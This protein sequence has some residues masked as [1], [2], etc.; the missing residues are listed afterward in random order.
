[1]GK[2][3]SPEEFL[4]F[5]QDIP[6]AKLR[7][8]KTEQCWNLTKGLGIYCS[9][10]YTI[11]KTRTDHIIIQ[12]MLKNLGKDRFVEYVNAVKSESR[13]NQVRLEKLEEVMGKFGVKINEEERKLFKDA[14][15]VSNKEEVV[16]NVE[17]LINFEK[18]QHI[19]KIYD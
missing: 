8:C 10:H 3:I 7:T 13:E 11:F 14:F 2:F 18:T 4:Y 9:L 19:G 16:V 17:K 15:G 6:P 12:R 5:R 1:M